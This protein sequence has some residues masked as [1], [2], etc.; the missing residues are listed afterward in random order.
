M[1]IVYRHQIRI[2][3]QEHVVP[4]SMCSRVVMVAARAQDPSAL[5]VW[6]EEE[7]E[8]VSPLN[9]TFKIFGTGHPLPFGW[10]HVGGAV[11][12]PFVWHLY[13]KR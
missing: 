4:T 3:D 2:D 9:R 6:I 5:S 8:S 11:A 1:R 12:E 10:D 7:T 13:E